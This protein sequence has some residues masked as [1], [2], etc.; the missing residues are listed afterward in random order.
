MEYNQALFYAQVHT[1]NQSHT[2]YLLAPT[3]MLHLKMTEPC[4]TA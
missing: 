3:R 1:L 4:F 2:T